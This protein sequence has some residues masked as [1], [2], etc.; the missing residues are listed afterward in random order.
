ML[1]T[2]LRWAASACRCESTR[3]GHHS[4]CHHR[5][6]FAVGHPPHRCRAARYGVLTSEATNA[7]AA[8]FGGGGL[9]AAVTGAGAGAASCR[10]GISQMLQPRRLREAVRPLLSTAEAD[11]STLGLGGTRRR[12]IDRRLS[13]DK[14]YRTFTLK[15]ARAFAAAKHA[16][17]HAAQNCCYRWGMEECEVRGNVE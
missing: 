8:R 12:I 11:S 9:G 15:L 6:H 3:D 10:P 7:G 4:R 17:K 14:S 13:A 1:R 16:V 2:R 5:L